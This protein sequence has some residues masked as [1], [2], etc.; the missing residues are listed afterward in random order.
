MGPSAGVAY[1]VANAPQSGASN[2]PAGTGQAIPV[3]SLFGNLKTS[4]L[5]Q[6]IVWLAAVVLVLIIWKLIEEHRGEVED[7]KEVK[8]GISNWAKIGIM[9]ILFF[10]TAKFLATKYD[11]PGASKLVVYATGG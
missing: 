2:T 10:A 5:N 7:F 8:I 9:M 6:P 1:S 4:F 11:V 3:I